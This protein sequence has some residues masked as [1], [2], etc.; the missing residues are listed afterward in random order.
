MRNEHKAVPAT[1]PTASE[2]MEYALWVVSHGATVVYIES[3]QGARY[4]LSKVL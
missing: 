4:R 1:R 2:A 3:P